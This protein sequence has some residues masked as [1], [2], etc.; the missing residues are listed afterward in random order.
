MTVSRI[1]NRW[2]Q[3]ANTKRS[4]R[5]QRPCITSSRE[6]WHGT[7]MA[8]MDYASMRRVLTRELGLFA[9]HQV[10][11]RTVRRRLLQ[12]GLSAR[13]PWLRLPLTLHHR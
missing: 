11:S 5:S 8:L 4:A 6:E 10:S 3:D 9:R 7:R 2:I 12:D 13:R 1:W